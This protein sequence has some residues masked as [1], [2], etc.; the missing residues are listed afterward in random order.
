MTTVVRPSVAEFFERFDRAG[1]ASDSVDAAALFHSTMLTLDPASVGAVTREQIVASLPMRR[2]FFAELGISRMRLDSLAESPIDD[3]HTLVRSAWRLE[4][5]P[6]SA[7]ANGTLFTATYLLRMVG[8][9][10]QIVVY[11]NHQDLRAL[12]DGT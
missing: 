12:A 9:A 10:W 5:T 2:R 11:L 1:E 4:T 6:D 7:V 3:R 8:D